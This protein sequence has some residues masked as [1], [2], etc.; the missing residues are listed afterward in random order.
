ML[1]EWSNIDPY[2]MSPVLLQWISNGNNEHFLRQSCELCICA[3]CNDLHDC[4]F[5]IVVAFDA[6]ASRAV[7]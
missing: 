6:F 7:L 2:I 5:L 1:H 3:L 4:G